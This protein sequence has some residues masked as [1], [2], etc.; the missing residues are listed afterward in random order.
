M[1]QRF[2]FVLLL[3]AG[4]MAVSCLKDDQFNYSEAKPVEVVGKQTAMRNFSVALSK[5]VCTNESARE[6]LKDEALKRV[7]NDYDVFYPFIKNLNQ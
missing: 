2:A 6:F 3:L 1:K 5:V 4:V 7:D